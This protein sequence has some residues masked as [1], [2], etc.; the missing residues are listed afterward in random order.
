MS[1]IFTVQEANGLIP[2]LRLLLT[3]VRDEKQRL[4]S[5]S[6]KMSGAKDGYLF[7]WGSPAGPEYIE[8]LD[9]F[10]RV[11][12]EIE[13]LGILVKDFEQGLCDFPHQRDGRIVHLC[14]K[15]DEEEV[16][17]WHEVDAGFTGRQ[18][19]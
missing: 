4:L 18:P 5:M 19:I 12:R 11:T 3:Q 17:W 1:R 15:M 16:T 8:I 2:Q 10:Y 14:W 13:N 7:D 9:A 6:P